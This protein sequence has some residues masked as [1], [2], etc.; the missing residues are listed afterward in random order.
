MRVTKLI[1]NKP[2]PRV[3]KRHRASGFIAFL[4]VVFASVGVFI[5]VIVIQALLIQMEDRASEADV[6]A[7]LLDDGYVLHQV[8][9]IEPWV[10]NE[11]SLE[12]DRH[13]PYAWARYL[14]ELR[15]R[16]KRVIR[17]EIAHGPSVLSWRKD[18]EKRLREVEK[19]GVGEGRFPPFVVVWRPLKP[20]EDPEKYLQDKALTGSLPDAR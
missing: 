17:V 11:V 6:Y 15:E 4:D 19:S 2:S 1:H 13:R 16:S 20:N 10:S 7:V 12:I 18:L 8:A 14:E 3:K 5:A 9:E